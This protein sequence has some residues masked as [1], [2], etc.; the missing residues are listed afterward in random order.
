MNP[1][2][3]VYIY[4]YMHGPHTHNTQH[5]AMQQQQHTHICVHTHITKEAWALRLRLRSTNFTPEPGKRHLVVANKTDRQDVHVAYFSQQHLGDT[6]KNELDTNT[7]KIQATKWTRKRAK[8]CRKFWT[9]EKLT[10]YRRT[11][12]K[13]SKSTS[14]NASKSS[15]VHRPCTNRR[16]GASVSIEFF[17]GA[18]YACTRTIHVCLYVCVDGFQK[19]WN[20]K[21]IGDKTNCFALRNIVGCFVL[22]GA[23]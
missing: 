9:V 20:M 16:K 8:S 17:F 2:Y 5:N 23:F 15:S 3:A 19:M 6:R 22:P 12:W 7:I 21:M 18:Y 1:A 13:K 4:I 10:K 14:T 11:Q